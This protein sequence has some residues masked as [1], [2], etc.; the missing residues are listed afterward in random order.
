VNRPKTAVLANKTSAGQNNYTKNISALT[1]VDQSENLLKIA[2]SGVYT[3]LQE[4]TL[5]VMSHQKSYCHITTTKGASMSKKV[6]SRQEKV[7]S[8]HNTQV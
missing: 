8:H 7:S 5:K 2:T 4:I 1:V 3:G 6:L